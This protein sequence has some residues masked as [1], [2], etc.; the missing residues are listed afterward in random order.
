MQPVTV[1]VHY[2]NLTP[3]SDGERPHVAG[4]GGDGVLVVARA[5]HHGRGAGGGGGGDLHAVRDLGNL[6][7]GTP[8]QWTG[9]S[10]KSFVK[11]RRVH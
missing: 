10:I 1:N 7:L 11:K 3:D 4:L 2:V 6:S 8:V 9:V 5:Q